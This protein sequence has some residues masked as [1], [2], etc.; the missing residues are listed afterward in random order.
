MNQRKAELMATNSEYFCPECEG[1]GEYDC[2][3]CGIGE[4]DCDHCEGTGWDPEQ[5]DVAAFQAAVEV[6]HQKA[7]DADCAFLSSELIDLKTNTRLGRDGGDFG[8][9]AVIDYLL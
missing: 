3:E 2:S 8:S 6:M 5:V 4:I 9:V 7:R 1:A